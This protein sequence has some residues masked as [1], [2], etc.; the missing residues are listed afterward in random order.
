MNKIQSGSLFTS[1]RTSSLPIV[2]SL[3]LLIFHCTN[4]KANDLALSKLDVTSMAGD[5]LQIQL[6]M[7]AEAVAPKVFHTDNPARIALDFVG[8]KNAL[9]KKVF[10]INQGLTTSVYIAEAADK[11]R[12]VVNL[13]E[14]MPFKQKL[15][16]IKCC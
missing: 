16:A 1:E 9:T 5:K 10:P 13:L 3:L 4:L 2:L 14:S 11:V 6:E 8:V 12:V 7:T 15:L